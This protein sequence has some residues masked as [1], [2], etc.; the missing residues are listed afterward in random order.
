MIPNN[1]HYNKK[2]D[3]G[4]EAQHDKVLTAVTDTQLSP[5]HPHGGWKEAIIE[6]ESLI[7]SELNR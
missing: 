6:S 5:L 4:E 1:Y 7:S 3:S 2:I